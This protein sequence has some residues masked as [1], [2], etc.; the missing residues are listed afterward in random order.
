MEKKRKPKSTFLPKKIY[1]REVTKMARPSVFSSQPFTTHFR[2]N[3]EEF[4]FKMY[5]KSLLWVGLTSA[6]FSNMV[7]EKRN[8]VGKVHPRL[9][10]TSNTLRVNH[11]L[12]KRGKFHVL[13][14]NH[15]VTDLRELNCLMAQ[16]S[17]DLE[18][19]ASTRTSNLSQNEP[20]NRSNT[21]VV[22]KLGYVWFS[23]RKDNLKE[24]SFPESQFSK[25]VVIETDLTGKISAIMIPLLHLY[26]ITLTARF[27]YV[28]FFP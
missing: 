20:S 10:P 24:I 5:P 4:F 6:Y 9:S 22:W 17:P 3:F 27:G 25:V 12:I 2:H 18:Q 15:C 19:I 28:F 23:H 8:A 1:E 13:Y 16:K 26:K 11:K 21:S 14:G 7:R